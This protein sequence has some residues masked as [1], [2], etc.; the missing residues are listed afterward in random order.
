MNVDIYISERE[1]SREVRIPWLPDKILYSSGGTTFA[2][3]DILNRGPVA[4]PTGSGLAGVKWD[5][6]LP[7]ENRTDTSMLRGKQKAPKYYHNIFEEWK[8]D[9]TPLR[10]MVTGYPINLDVYLES[11]EAEASGGFG[12]MAYS[13]VFRETRE[14]KITT[15]K[16]EAKKPTTKRSTTTSQTYT[17]KSGDCLWSIAEK[18]KG[19]G[20]SWTSIYSANKEVIESTAKSRGYSDSNNGWWIFPGCTLTIP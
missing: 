13:I 5:G 8:K 2:E 15:V 10:I 12:D 9:G 20:A 3:Y 17:V 16:T 1:G 4:V 6:E 19:S 18:L 11:Y 14:I 7:G